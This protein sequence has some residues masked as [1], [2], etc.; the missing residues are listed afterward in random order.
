MLYVPAVCLF[1]YQTVY[2]MTSGSGQRLSCVLEF[3]MTRIG[4]DAMC[5]DVKS[6]FRHMVVVRVVVADMIEWRKHKL[7]FTPEGI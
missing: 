6:R 2:Q 7:F 5:F 1:S 4:S 3:E